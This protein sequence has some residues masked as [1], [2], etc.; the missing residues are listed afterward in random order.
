MPNVP[1][2]LATEQSW[3]CT[4]KL[5]YGVILVCYSLLFQNTQGLV[6]YEKKEREREICLVHSSGGSRASSYFH[7]GPHGR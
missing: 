7:E 4:G 1:A 5:F 2:G 6:L 3:F